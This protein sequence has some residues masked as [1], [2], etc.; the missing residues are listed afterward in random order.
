MPTQA[1]TY[2]N[3]KVRTGN[4][5]KVYF[6]GVEVGLVKSVEA[7]DDYGLDA[8]TGIGDIHVQEYVPTVARHTLSVSNLVLRTTSMRAAGIVPENGDGALKGLV[9]DLVSTD[10]ATGAI[11]RTY[12]GC[13]YASGN[14]SVSANQIVVQS[15][16]FMCLDV[17]GLGV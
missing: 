8:A 5:I 6:G 9:F 10:L 11:L 12:R 13:S 17:S 1:Q 15:G 14:T 4:L 16:Q 3:N 7:S 2:S